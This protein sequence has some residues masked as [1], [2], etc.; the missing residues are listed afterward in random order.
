MVQ[1][2]WDTAFGIAATLV[3]AAILIVEYGL[4]TKCPKCGARMV[5]N[6]RGYNKWDCMNCG[7]CQK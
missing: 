2:S 4:S 3:L 6:E 5:W 1:V 7:H